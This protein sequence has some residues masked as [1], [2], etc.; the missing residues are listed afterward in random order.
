MNNFEI[1]SN[2]KVIVP[3]MIESD[4]YKEE[5]KQLVEQDFSSLGE[6][7][8][9]LDANDAIKKY[10]ENKQDFEDNMKFMSTVAVISAIF[11]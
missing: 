10:R 3:L 9:A 1:L 8:K 7:I 11:S 6:Q 2:G 4:T 5:K